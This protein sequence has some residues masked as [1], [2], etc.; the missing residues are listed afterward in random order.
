VD[1]L[2]QADAGFQLFLQASMKIKVVMPE[3]LLDHQ[4]VES[5]KLFQVLE[6]IE[7][8]GGIGVAAEHYLRPA[9]ANFL[10]NLDVPSRLALDLDAAVAG[11]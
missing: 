4:Q 3:R 2:I 11:V 8:V 9:R 6:L 5:V 7:R 1:G 10:K